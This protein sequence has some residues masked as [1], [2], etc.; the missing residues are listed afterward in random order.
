MNLR[1]WNIYFRWEIA[2]VILLWWGMAIFNIVKVYLATAGL[3]I[4]VSIL[5][6]LVLAFN[7]LKRSQ[8]SLA[9]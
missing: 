9:G 3:C 5:P 8:Q 6:V 2:I 4:V 7:W 1:K